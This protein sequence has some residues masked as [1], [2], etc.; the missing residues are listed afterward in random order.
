MRILFADNESRWLWEEARARSA[1]LLPVGSVGQRERLRAEAE[2][3]RYHRVPEPFAFLEV[4]P[5]G[6]E[7]ASLWV[8]RRGDDYLAVVACCEHARAVA[9]AARELRTASVF[10]RLPSRPRPLASHWLRRLLGLR[11]DTAWDVLDAISGLAWP[12]GTVR[13]CVYVDWIPEGPA[14]AA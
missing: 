6:Q 12:P 14:P 2:V 3:A 7:D 5:S 4:S 8:V 13:P 1:S 9:L 10:L 11:G